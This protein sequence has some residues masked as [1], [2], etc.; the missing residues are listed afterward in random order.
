M[1]LSDLS[2]E[3]AE[4]ILQVLAPFANA[5]D[6]LQ[7]FSDG[8]SDDCSDDAVLAVNDGGREYELF[9]SKNEAHGEEPTDM[10]KVSHLAEAKRL[11]DIIRKEMHS[12]EE[13]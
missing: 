10:L 12:E 6:R 11:V 2:Q 13:E 8:S 1:R 7:H 3:D 9:A 5:Y 4:L